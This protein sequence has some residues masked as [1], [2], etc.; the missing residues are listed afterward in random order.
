MWVKIKLSKNYQKALKQIDAELEYWPDITIHKN[1]QRLTKIF[2][3]LLRIKKLSALPRPKLVPLQRNVEKVDRRR[4]ARAET[5]ARIDN[6]IEDELLKR[7]QS[8]TYGDI[9]NFP[10]QQYNKALERE[11]KKARE[12]DLNID[13]FEEA[14]ESE[15]EEEEREVEYLNEE[16]FQE[17]DQDIED[18]EFANEPSAS[19]ETSSDEAEREHKRRSDRFQ[20]KRVE[21][22]QSK[23][24]KPRIELELEEEFDSTAV[25]RTDQR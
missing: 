3:Y 25:V 20:T 14:Y 11:V 18:A 5:V 23:R 7:L 21:R 12:V 4:E 2:Q 19:D 6:A 15:L 17:S 8:G 16:D 24:K 10:L 13:E 9:Y 22:K 1:K